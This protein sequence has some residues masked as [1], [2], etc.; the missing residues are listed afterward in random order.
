MMRKIVTAASVTRI[1]D[2]AN[3]AVPENQRS[4]GRCLAGIA[5]AVVVVMRSCFS[6]RDCHGDTRPG[7]GAAPGV[8]GLFRDDEGD[9]RVDLLAQRVRDGRV[10]GGRGC[11]LPGP[12]RSRR[13][14]GTTLTTAAAAGVGVLLRTRSCSSRGR[15]GRRPSA[16]EVR[17]SSIARSPSRAALF[18]RATRRRSRRLLRASS[19]TNSSPTLIAAVLR[20]SSAARDASA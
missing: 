5:G 6:L 13:T 18:E 1:I 3:S 9:R 14:R 16:S 2:P 19:V 15:W 10:A 12:P 8:G 17:S 7:R 4:P 20:P 11:R